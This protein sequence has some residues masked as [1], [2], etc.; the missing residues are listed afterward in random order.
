[1]SKYVEYFQ[2]EVSGWQRKLMVADLVISSWMSVQRTWAHLNSIFTNSHDI[3]CQLANDAERF[4]GIH[5]DFQ[6]TNKYISFLF[7]TILQRQHHNS[8]PQCLMKETVQNSNVVEVTNQPGFL[9]NLETLQQRL[10]VCEKALAEYL[11]TKRLTFP[12]FY[13]VSA[14]DLLEIVS[15]GTQPKEVTS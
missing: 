5:T 8:L 4:Q 15:K 13:F 2:A 1:M 12:R 3:R 11:E 7:K 6:V 10:S 9:E 14:S